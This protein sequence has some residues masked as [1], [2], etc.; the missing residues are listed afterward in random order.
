MNAQT[1]QFFVP[2]IPIPNPKLKNAV[3]PPR[4][5][6]LHGWRENV[7][8]SARAASRGPVQFNGP[9]RLECVFV[10]PARP[11]VAPGC[12]YTCKPDNDNLIK[13]VKDALTGVLW[14][15]DAIV[16]CE[17]ATKIAAPEG[18]AVG[19]LITVQTYAIDPSESIEL[20]RSIHLLRSSPARTPTTADPARE[21]APAAAT[22][23]ASPLQPGSYDF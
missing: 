17:K 2:G 6:P 14:R 1:L 22:Q 20:W 16:V 13:P 19:A 15:D 23:P 9:V 12:P 3:R 11:A 21:N 8:W 7:A 5:H 18:C 10:F 4:A